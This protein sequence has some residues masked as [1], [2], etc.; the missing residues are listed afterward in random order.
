MH[1]PVTE[2]RVYR[3]DDFVALSPSEHGEINRIVIAVI[4]ANAIKFSPTE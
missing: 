2:E 4:E 3:E 1:L